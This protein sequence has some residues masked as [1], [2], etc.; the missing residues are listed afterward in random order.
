MLNSK[1][2][3]PYIVQPSLSTNLLTGALMKRLL[4]TAISMVVL[5]CATTQISQAQDIRHRNFALDTVF[6][7]G[8]HLIALPKLAWDSLRIEFT[9]TYKGDFPGIRHAIQTPGGWY[10]S[11]VQRMYLQADDTTNF[12]NGMRYKFIFIPTQFGQLYKNA[13]AV[14]N[15][16]W[17][18]PFVQNFG[19]SVVNIDGNS[20]DSVNSNGLL[21]AL[22]IMKDTS[23]PET[24]MMGQG[25]Y[26]STDAFFESEIPKL[27]DTLGISRDS[28]HF[29]KIVVALKIDPAELSE[30]DFD[31]TALVYVDLYHRIRSH[32]SDTTCKC[33]IYEKFRRLAITKGMMTNPEPPK[34][35][36]TQYSEVT[37]WLDMRDSTGPWSNGTYNYHSQI[38][39]W[40]V[41]MGRYYRGVP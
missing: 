27:Y 6:R 25:R 29:L 4:L 20:W 1:E 39:G 30:I 19:L 23:A 33:N 22:K 8:T 41:R 32:Q 13:R 38:G 7:I 11:L 36:I 24:I 15:Y 34:D 3:Q 17:V 31:T 40:L 9:Q 21:R 12:Q 5:F 14:D 35:P 16:P 2:I 26:I 10:D 37:F 18:D 28:A